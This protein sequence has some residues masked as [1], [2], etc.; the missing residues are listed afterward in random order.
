MVK[1]FVSQNAEFRTFNIDKENAF[2]SA[3]TNGG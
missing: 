1:N 2:I 3:N